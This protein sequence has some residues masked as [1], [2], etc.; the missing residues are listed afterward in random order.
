VVPDCRYVSQMR[1]LRWLGS[2]AVGQVYTACLFRL[3]TV[4]SPSLVVPCRDTART[5]RL[6]F[7]HGTGHTWPCSRLVVE[8]LARGNFFFYLARTDRFQQEVYRLANLIAGMYQNSAE[9]AL[10]QRA[11]SDLRI[12]YWDWAK[13]APPGQTQFPDVF[14]DAVI[15]QTGPRGPQLIRNPLYSYQFRPVNEDAFIWAPV[16]PSVLLV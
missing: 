4:S 16:S 8:A 15:T 9:R 5:V 7:R 13:D 11:A 3:G 10:Y 12:P 14:W 1:W 6:C 2:N